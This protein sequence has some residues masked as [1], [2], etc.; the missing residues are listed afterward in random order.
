MHAP[1]LARPPRASPCPPP[2]AA[3]AVVDN[4]NTRVE[5]IAAAPDADRR[6]DRRHRPDAQARLAQLLGEPRRGGLR[7][8]GDVDAAAGATA[9]P[10]RFPVPGTLLVA[11][12]MNYVYEDPATL[13]TTVTGAGGR[14]SRSS[15]TTSSAPPRCA[16]PKAPSCAARP[17]AAR[18][19]SRALRRRGRRA[20]DARSRARASP[21]TTAASRSP[22]PSP[23][24]R[25]SPHAY[26]FPA[27]DGVGRLCRAAGRHRRRA[28]TC[29]SRPRPAAQGRRPRV[30][31][32]LRVE[33]GARSR[34]YTI[35]RDARAG[36]RR[37]SATA[38]P[39]RRHA[40]ACSPPR[41]SS[42]SPAGVVLNVMPCVFPILSLK[43]LSLAKGG[44]TPA[45]ARRDALA[46]AAGVDRRVRRARR[47]RP[48][49]ARGGRRGRLGVPAAEPAR[50]RRRC[51]CSSPRS[52][53]TSPGCSSSAASA[54]ARRSR[55]K[56]G[57]A[58][59]FWTG[60]LAA[61]VATPCTG[62]FMAA[63][64]GAALVLPPVAGL[65][66]LRR[67]RP[68]A[69]AA[70]PRDRLRPRAAPPPAEARRVDGDLPPPAQRADVRD[71][72][73]PRVAA[74]AAG[75]RRRHDAGPRPAR[76]PRGSPCGGSADGSARSRPAGRRWSPA[77]VAA[78]VAVA[79]VA[80]R[81]RVPPRRPTPPPAS[82]PRRSAKRALAALPAEPHPGV[83]LFHRRLVPDVQGQ[84]ARRA[85]PTPPS[86]PRSSAKGVTTLV[87]DWTSSDPA[88]GRFIHAHNRAGVPL[89]LFYHADGRVEALPQVLTTGEL[90]Q[91]AA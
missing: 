31:G 20:A 65:L 8:Q 42:R 2:L 90:T 24:R 15:S 14:R 57:A 3:Q 67:A 6:A 72:A 33:R 4:P 62:P 60:A 64:L 66:G 63:A 71:R 50:R 22:C 38:P 61:F 32:V 39:R 25:A 19:R 83:R 17:P 76:S 51:C 85:Q 10:L 53:S 55:A 86:P 18:A 78:V 21:S 88:L 84:R 29:G 45:D 27:A 87:G 91:R 34:G 28:L 70:V 41:C 1:P 52:R 5:L 37:R 11:G 12:L 48:R 49:A 73:R 77:L 30:G 44:A 80:P 82:P 35:D 59:S 68:R 43:A 36:S 54:A 69:G 13:V 89:Y 56:P 26:F 23:T 16:C 58:G 75:G 47:G 81:D 7:A 9:A 74:R 46:Y 40:R 79:A